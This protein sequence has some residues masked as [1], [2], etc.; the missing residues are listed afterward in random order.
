MVLKFSGRPLSCKIVLLFHH[1]FLF[2][3]SKF[4]PICQNEILLYDYFPYWCQVQCKFFF[5]SPTSLLNFVVH[6]FMLAIKTL[7]TPKCEVIF[8][9]HR[10]KPPKWYYVHRIIQSESRRVLLLALDFI[11]CQILNLA[12]L[13]FNF[14]WYFS[15]QTLSCS[16][17]CS[18]HSL[19]C[20]S[21]PSVKPT[22]AFSLFVFCTLFWVSAPFLSLVILWSPLSRYLLHCL[23]PTDMLHGTRRWTCQSSCQAHL[24]S[25]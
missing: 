22:V 11:Q 21:N 15:W 14:S 1:F 8:W 19:S 10:A 12:I 2:Y 17:Y 7:L 5:G 3:I 16:L 25:P 24:E 9:H 18:L 20:C 6:S 23:N 13:A 4:P